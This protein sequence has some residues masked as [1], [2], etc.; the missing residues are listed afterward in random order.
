[1]KVKVIIIKDDTNRGGVRARSGG[2][3]HARAH[4][5]G[6][7]AEGS[8]GARGDRNDVAHDGV[9]DDIRDDR[10]LEGRMRLSRWTDAQDHTHRDV[11]SGEVRGG[12]RDDIRGDDHDVVGSVRD[13]PLQRI[14]DVRIRDRGDHDDRGVRSSGAHS[15]ARGG[16][17]R[18][19]LEKE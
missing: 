7:S 2:H 5:R 12:V 8:G 10:A 16:G 6:E 3:V 17:D 18:V 11:R 19:L 13:V 9:R 14:R 4:D 15:G 1:M